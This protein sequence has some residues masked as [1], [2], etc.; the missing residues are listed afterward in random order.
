[1]LAHHKLAPV[2]HG[3]HGQAA[4]LRVEKGLGTG[5]CYFSAINANLTIL[6]LFIPTCNILTSIESG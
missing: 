4:L 3:R 1:M 5:M 2:V 6:S